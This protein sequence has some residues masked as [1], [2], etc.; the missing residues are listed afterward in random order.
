MSAGIP[1]EG[2]CV[3]VAVGL[4]SAYIPQ[5]GECR[6]CGQFNVSMHTT[7]RK[8]SVDLVVSLIFGDRTHAYKVKS[9]DCIW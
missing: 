2:Q 4:M 9:T 7:L 8:V 6:P 3:D 1:Q 5:E